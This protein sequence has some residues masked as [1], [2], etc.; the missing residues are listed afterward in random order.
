MAGQR[1]PYGATPPMGMGGPGGANSPA[2][3]RPQGVTGPQ[4][5]STMGRQANVPTTPG[6][7]RPASSSSKK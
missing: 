5:F 3:S 6:G 1:P 7:K 4:Q 2:I